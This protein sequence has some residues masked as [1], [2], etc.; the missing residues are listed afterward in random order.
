MVAVVSTASLEESH[1]YT[2]RACSGGC[3]MHDATGSLLCDFGSSYTN[4]VCPCAVSPAG[5]SQEP[6]VSPAPEGAQ[7]VVRAWTLVQPRVFAP[8]P[9]ARLQR[10]TGPWRRVSGQLEDPTEVFK[11]Q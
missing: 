5:V 9:K 1:S 7:H 3:S 11:G 10:P 2:G 4:S 8:L 6:Q